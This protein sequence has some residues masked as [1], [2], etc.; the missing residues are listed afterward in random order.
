MSRLEAEA[1]ARWSFMQKQ[2]NKHWIWIAMEAKTR[3]IIA[4]HMGDRSR[5]SAKALWATLPE[6]SRA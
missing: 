5:E 1:D 2:A 3:Q 6:V 4:G